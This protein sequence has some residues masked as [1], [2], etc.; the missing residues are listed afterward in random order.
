LY[1]LSIKICGFDLVYELDA[2]HKWALD[3]LLPQNQTTFHEN[4]LSEL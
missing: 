1:V 4:M 3:L 2:E